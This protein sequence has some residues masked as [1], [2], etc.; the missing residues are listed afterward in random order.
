M[1]TKHEYVDVARFAVYQGTL[2]LIL[3][4]VVFLFRNSV[5]CRVMLVLMM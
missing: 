5:Q 2:R 1:A 3:S 4:M